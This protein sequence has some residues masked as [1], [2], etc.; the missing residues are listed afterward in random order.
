MGHAQAGENACVVE[1][2]GG[3]RMFSSPEN[4]IRVMDSHDLVNWRQSMDDLT[5]G[6]AEWD[7]AKGRLTAGFV[8]ENEKGF[9]NLPHWIMFFHAS[10]YPETIEFDSY[11]SIAIAYSDDLMTWRWPGKA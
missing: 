9:G 7:W 3:Y 1:Y 10:R 5:L 6:Q 4:G 11:A 8:M 2:N